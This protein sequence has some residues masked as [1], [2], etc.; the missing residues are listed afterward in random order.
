[1]PVC[2]G[3]VYWTFK[4][5]GGV[6]G[7]GGVGGGQQTY[8]KNVNKH[9]IYVFYIGLYMFYV[10]FI[11]MFYMFYIS[12]YR[13]LPCTLRCPDVLEKLGSRQAPFGACHSQKNKF[14]YSFIEGIEK[15]LYTVFYI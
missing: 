14:V 8:K 1:M 13:L 2:W 10:G 15:G 5:S 9:Y 6:D 4:Q 7:V 3:F 12:F 11:Y